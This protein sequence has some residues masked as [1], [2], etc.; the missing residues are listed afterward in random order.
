[1]QDSNSFYID[2]YNKFILDKIKLEK[3][4]FYKRKG[5]GVAIYL[6]NK[7]NSATLDQSLSV[8]TVDA[9]IL[10]V[11]FTT[12]KNY[13]NFVIG[14]YR[15][16]SGN[17]NKFIEQLDSVISTIN[18]SANT[19]IHIQGD[20]NLNLYNPTSKNVMSYLECVFSNGLHP[21]ISRAT[22]FMG[23]NPTCIDHILSNNVDYVLTSGVIPYN[24]S[25]HMPIF[26]IV[27]DKFSADNCN[28]PNT[29]RFCINDEKLNGFDVEFKKRLNESPNFDLDESSAKI[30][31]TTF[32][33]IFKELYDKW[34]LHNSDK[35]C[36][37]IHTKSEW[38]NSNIAKSCKIKN[39]LY[40]TWR[41]NRTSKNWT[42]Y[43]EY[44]RQLDTV[45]AKAKFDF[46]NKKF[47][48]CKSDL[49][50]TWCNINNILGRKKRNNLLTFNT[51]EAS[52]NFNKYFTSI[53][54]N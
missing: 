37:Y 44:K 36:K 19:S 52:H 54:S 4:D 50:K 18:T 30:N 42:K 25:H 27:K 51:P 43:L 13:T 10:T 15:P 17:V 2:G 1:M 22:H 39:Q 33:D 28:Q 7:Y 9:E 5:S 24:I 23:R 38:I 35:K 31:F 48:A 11:K 3:S 20:F 32:L 6:D 12:G 29:P 41:K 16:P 45:I 46:Y 8:C 47:N 49:K 26:S 40:L 53:A 14:V 34:F 21:L